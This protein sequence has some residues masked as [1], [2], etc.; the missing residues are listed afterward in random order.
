MTKLRVLEVANQRIPEVTKL[1]NEEAKL[2]ISGIP[3]MTKQT[4]LEVTK[5]RIPEVAKQRIL[6]VTKLRLS[7]I[8]EVTKLR[9]SEVTKLSRPR[10][11][12]WVIWG[13]CRDLKTAIS[14]LVY[15]CGATYM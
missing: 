4:I 10:P 15:V 9:F 2:R 6:E 1:K 13:P 11:L 3:E 5:R 8:P 14:W 12:S 7:R